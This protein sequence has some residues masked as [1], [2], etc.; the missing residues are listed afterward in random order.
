MPSF[1]EVNPLP[2]LN[3]EDSDLPIIA[4][5]EGVSYQ[6]VIREIIESALSRIPPA[7]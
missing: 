5:Q 6:D 1:M 4:R 3:P 7:V 2:G